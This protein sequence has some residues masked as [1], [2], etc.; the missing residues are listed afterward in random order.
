MVDVSLVVVN[1]T[2]CSALLS[3]CVYIPEHLSCEHSLVLV[4]NL[5]VKILDFSWFSLNVVVDFE[6]TYVHLVSVVATLNAQT[7]VLDDVAL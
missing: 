4:L 7:D 1:E 6:L 2:P 5:Y 3:L